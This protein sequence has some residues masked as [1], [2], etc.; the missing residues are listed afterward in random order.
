MSTPQ[1]LK[2]T[3]RDT[4]L[5]PRQLRAAGYIPATLYGKGVE[6]QSIQV[7]AHEF[8]QL[9]LQ[10]HKEFTLTGLGPERVVRTQQL[11]VEPVSRKPIS[12]EFYQLSPQGSTGNQPKAAKKPA[13]KPAKAEKPVEEAAPEA[14]TVLTGA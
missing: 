1:E 9:S 14:E 12:I 11:Q 3:E 5:T 8:T 2:A 6:S 4:T 10:G 13:E 7:R